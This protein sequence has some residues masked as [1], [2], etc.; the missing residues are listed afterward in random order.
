MHQKRNGLHNRL[1]LVKK[2]LGG[3]RINLKRRVSIGLS[4][5]SEKGKGRMLGHL[6]EEGE[7]GRLRYDLVDKRRTD[8]GASN[9]L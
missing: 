4:T 8:G 3:G 7:G 9:I 6:K 2:F 5:E 1:D